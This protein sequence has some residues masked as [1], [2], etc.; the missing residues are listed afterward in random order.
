VCRALGILIYEMLAGHS[1]FYDAGGDGDQMTICR[2]ILHA[3]LKFPSGFT[4]KETKDVIGKLLTRDVL[5]RFGCQR[6]GA[7]DIKHHGW[8]KGAVLTACVLCTFG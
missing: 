3:P 2:N 6:R 8:F 1:P 7:L 5:Q 4:G